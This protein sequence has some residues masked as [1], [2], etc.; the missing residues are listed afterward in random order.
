MTQD[1]LAVLAEE[2]AAR[3]LSFEDSGRGVWAV[4]IAHDPAGWQP[5]LAEAIAAFLWEE[6]TK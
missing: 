5:A 6:E 4:A 2:E 3:L 1:G